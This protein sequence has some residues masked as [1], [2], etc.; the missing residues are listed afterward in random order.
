MI[1]SSI[2]EKFLGLYRLV[3]RVIGVNPFYIY[4]YFKGIPFFV[5]DMVKY[6]LKAKDNDTF[7]IKLQNIYPIFGDRFSD[8]GSAKGH[9]F[10]QDIWAAKK[11]YQNNPK[12]HLD[13][14]SRVDGFI[15]HLL[16]FRHVTVI[17][18][19]PLQSKV[20]NLSYQQGDITSLHFSDNSIRSLSSLHAIEHIGLGRYGDKIDAKGWQKALLEIQRVLQVG[21]KL[22]LGLPIGKEC[23]YFNA[24]RVFDVN[25]VINTL[26]ELS[27]VSFSYIDDDGDFHESTDISSPVTEMRYGCGLFEFTKTLQ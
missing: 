16:V 23:V 13:I 20:D 19:R 4:Y 25:T 12:E 1:I 27:L 6:Y 15:S 14:G 5:L 26:N 7:Q 18:I 3:F 10:H 17:D 24:H 21:G 9:Y 8:A 22:Y 2:K 11:I